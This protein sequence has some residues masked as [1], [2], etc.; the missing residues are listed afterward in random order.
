MRNTLIERERTKYETI[1]AIDAYAEHSPGEM[2][3]PI[4]RDMTGAESGTVLDAGC[5]SGKG[6]IAL[7]AAGFDVTLCDLTP[8]GLVTAAKSLPFVAASLWDDLTLVAYL[9]AGGKVDYVYCCVVLEHIPTAFTML[10]IAR[11]LAVAKRG[12]F[13][14]ISTVPDVHGVLVGEPLHQTVHSFVQ[15]RDDLSE[16][17]RVVQARDLLVSGCYLV[18]PVR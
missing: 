5:G 7:A 10:V 3:L 2:V 8:D 11:L 14:S 1:W 16:L 6:A 12:L 15:W 9:A 18:E 4:F 17:G 13:L